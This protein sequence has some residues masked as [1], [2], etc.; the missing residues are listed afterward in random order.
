MLL[1]IGNFISL[2]G[3]NIQQFVLSLYVLSITG[4]AT[5][6]AS[7]L[8]VSILPRILLSPI[9]G[10]FG[11]WFDKKKAIV[12]LDIA[13]AIFLFG[14][15][16]LIY[17][18]GDVSIFIIY[19]LVIVLEITEVFFQSAM[20]VVLPSVVDKEQYLEANSLRVMLVSF[21]Q[22]MGPIIGAILFS[23][24]GLMIAVLINAMSFLLS[25]ISELF[26]YIPKIKKKASK[27]SVSQF[28]KEFISGLK[29]IKESKV[30]KLVISLAVV[31]NFSVAPLFS[32]GIIFLV[33]EVLLQ[34]DLKFGLLQTILSLSMIVAPIVFTKK[35][36]TIKFGD[37][38]IKLFSALGILIMLISLSINNQIYALY[39]G[40]VS[41]GIVVLICFLIGM[42]VTAINISAQTILQKIVPL[43]YMGRVSTTLSLFGIIAIPLGQMLFGYLY[44]IINPGI[45]VILNG[46]III[47]VIAFFYQK[48]REIDVNPIENI[49]KVPVERSVLVNEV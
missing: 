21:G 26:I 43:E 8:A 41:Y 27:L 44:D 15:A 14:F 7:M 2:L 46:L 29:I 16:A 1:V 10:V 20:S 33:K 47:I 37:G 9:A 48:L 38:L 35:L 30:L 32:V 5:L 40:N 42:L 31:V 19:I 24:F 18:Q 39:Q 4:S 45:V 17:Y 36:K 11:D 12:I 3:S 34:S 22:L 25:A 28:K 13:N 23:S 6:F 49:T